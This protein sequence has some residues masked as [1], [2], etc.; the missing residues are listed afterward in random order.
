MPSCYPMGGQYD[1]VVKFIGIENQ[2]SWIGLYAL[3]FAISVI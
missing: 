1:I 2:I 3:F